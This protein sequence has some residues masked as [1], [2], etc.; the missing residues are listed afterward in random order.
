ME[1]LKEY[2]T[3][4]QQEYYKYEITK[5]NQNLQLKNNKKK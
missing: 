2:S 3:K 4:V 1:I 5:K